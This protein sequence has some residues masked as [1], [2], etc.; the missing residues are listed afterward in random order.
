MKP[1]FTKKQICTISKYAADCV[2]LIERLLASIEK[3]KES[4]KVCFPSLFNLYYIDNDWITHGKG[5]EGKPPK[6]K[7]TTSRKD[8]IEFIYDCTVLT[9]KE[10][11]EIISSL[12]KIIADRVSACGEKVENFDLFGR[13]TLVVEADK[14]SFAST[15]QITSENPSDYIKKLSLQSGEGFTKKK[16]ANL[17]E[18]DF[19]KCTSILKKIKSRTKKKR[20]AVVGFETDPF[21][22]PNGVTSLC[23]KTISLLSQH[24]GFL[25]LS[26]LKSIETLD[27]KALATYSGCQFKM[28]GKGEWPVMRRC[29]FILGGITQ[30][31]EKAAQELSKFDDTEPSWVTDLNLDWP[32]E[33]ANNEILHDF[34][35]LTSISSK[36]LSHLAKLNGHLN[37]N[38]LKSIDDQQARSLEKHKGGLSLNG[39]VS[40]TPETA[41]SLAK[42]CAKDYEVKGCSRIQLEGIQELNAKVISA[43]TKTNSEH[44]EHPFAIDFGKVNRLSLD[45]AKE[46]RDYLGYITISTKEIEFQALDLLLERRDFAS[47]LTYDSI[48]P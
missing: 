18:L 41:Q 16:G 32:G 24:K 28:E 11:T 4:N 35:G 7:N 20:D 42:M 45:M 23:S 33:Y 31:S 19:E 6:T 34:S 17:S 37:F 25:D 38:G 22:I 2:H 15:S 43:L 46:F 14:L 47:S 36:A 29:G 9:K 10:I 1:L 26:A 27:A 3:E 21:Y 13:G 12:D 5:F 48:V 8:I 44:E 39:I 30:I 40:I